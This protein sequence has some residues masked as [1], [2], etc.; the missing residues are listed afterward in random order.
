VGEPDPAERIRRVRELVLTAVGEPAINAMSA[1][2]PVMSRLPQAML[3][4][5][6]GLTSSTDVQASN[7]PGYADAPYIAGAK[8]VKSLPFGPLPGVPMMIILVTEAGM[9]YVGVHYDTAAVTHQDLFAR[10]LQEGFDEVLALAD[11]EPSLPPSAAK[12]QTTKARSR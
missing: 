10:C 11:A 1:V 4:V 5:L 12:R 3:G 2:A 7:V 8:I 6:S 9:C